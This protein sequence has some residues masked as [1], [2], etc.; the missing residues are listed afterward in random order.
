MR[1]KKEDIF[2]GTEEIISGYLSHREEIKQN[3]VG[4]VKHSPGSPY[5]TSLA[6]SRLK[7]NTSS[8]KGP[9]QDL[10]ENSLVDFVQGSKKEVFQEVVEPG[11]S[12]KDESVKDTVSWVEVAD[13]R[14]CTNRMGTLRT[15]TQVFK[16]SKCLEHKVMAERVKKAQISDGR[17]S[18]GGL[19]SFKRRRLDRN[20]ILEIWPKREDFRRA[21]AMSRNARMK[22]H[23]NY[24][25]GKTKSRNRMFNRA[26]DLLIK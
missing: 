3:V 23:S 14:T 1:S 20:A 8:S 5:S 16:N 15:G 4:S 13:N 10:T 18:R 19:G 25:K 21:W 17:Y 6:M 9:P 26:I 12:V 7:V 22:N 24:R 2:R 11:E